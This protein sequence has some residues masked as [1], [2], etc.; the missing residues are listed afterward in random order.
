MK[1]ATKLLLAPVLTAVVALSAGLVNAVL[2]GRE[3]GRM[4]TQAGVAQDRYKTLASVQFQLGQVHV[5]AYRTVGLV[6]SL[7][8]AKVK[9]IRGE[10]GNQLAGVKRT[11]EATVGADAD[12]AMRE[13]MAASSKAL[14]A[15]AKAA[16]VAIDLA[17]VDPN[18]GI[19]A[20]Q[21]ADAAHEALKTALGRVVA[22]DEQAAESVAD[23][24]SQRNRNTTLFMALVGVIAAG[25]AIWLSWRMQRQIVVDLKRAGS[26]ADAVADGD[27]TVDARSDRTD[28]V[29]DLIRSLHSMC[30]QLSSSL[31]TV[32]ESSSSI[33]QSSAE[34][35][36]GNQDLSQRTEHAASNLQQTANS[37]GELTG[38]VQQSADSART[39][40]QLAGSAAQVA[41]RGGEVV[42]Q[43][44]STMEEI[45]SSSKKIADIIGVI[46]SIAFQTNILALNAAVEAARAGE[47]G[48]GF[49]VVASEVRS[50]AQRSAGAAK[51]IKSLIDTSVDK[52]EAG[53]RLVQD[54]GS[55]MNEIVASVQRVTDIIAEISASTVEQS[56]GIAQV[57]E[58]VNQL[59]QMT[60]QNAA[61]VEESAAAAESLKDQAVRLSD[62]VGGFRL[63]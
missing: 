13:A 7:D 34:I 50:L 20:M 42:G 35:A 30:T 37:M 45:N 14:D 2:I 4:Q 23:A 17:T 51:E 18:T 44:V 6:A 12:A 41:Q 33:Q 10:L 11:L 28:E 8:D 54:A 60:Q 1:L 40:N 25:A 16:D 47:Q 62:V 46:D 52:V 58:A 48:R 61:L 32:R 43:V 24:S 38:T 29:G 39:A 55:T 57:N 26:L 63:R 49:A 5:A 3:A 59:D 31:R 19:A 9:S 15:Y 53:S 22:H 27:L 21:Q 56:Q 36:S